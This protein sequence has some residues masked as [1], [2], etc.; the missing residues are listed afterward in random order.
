MLPSV[1]DQPV[2]PGLFTEAGLIGGQCGACGRRHFPLA[3]LCPWCGSDEVS[4]VLL[5]SEGTLWG[6]TAV[7]AAPPGY[8]GP[9]PY[10]FGV[11]SL[12]TDGLQVV[13]RLVEADPATLQRDDAMRFTTV[14]LSDG[15]VTWAFGRARP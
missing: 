14:P 4:E 11:V 15:T 13:T 1:P 9:V 10:G 2:H 3:G 7:T 6:W 12:P 5:S 8:D